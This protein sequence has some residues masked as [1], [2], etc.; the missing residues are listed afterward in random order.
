MS[1]ADRRI[2]AIAT[3]MSGTDWALLLVLSVLWGGS[4]FFV[5]VA[6]KALPLFTIVFLR[7]AIAAL[8][9]QAVLP[10]LGIRFPLRREA[11]IAFF[12][13]GLLNN[14]IPF[15]L[16]VYGQ[17]EI[18]SGLASILNATTPLFAV[19]LTHFLTPDEKM[20]P[21][22]L[23]GVVLGFIGVVVMIGGSAL[24]GVGTHLLAQGAVL[25][26]AVSYGFATIYGR[27]FRR[28]GIPPLAT[29]TGQ[30]SASTLMLVPVVLV[31]DRPWTLSLPGPGVVLSV[32][33]LAV[34]STA[35]AYILYFRILATSGATNIALV[36]FLVPVTA[37][38]LGTFSLGETLLARHY[39]GMALIALGLVAMDGRAFRS[40]SLRKPTAD[41][42]AGI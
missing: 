35:I 3:T 9:L 29:A 10:L 13:M 7:V 32:V 27:R 31:A 2:S 15:T 36:T 8:V 1:T 11:L 6:V 25:G 24:G 40:L 4:F 28:M 33:A 30:V 42:G 16:I 20:T 19:V 37:I 23:A 17:R 34:V 22:K 12:G 14:V 41:P 18:A 26:A 38:L 21:Q 5:G 39:V